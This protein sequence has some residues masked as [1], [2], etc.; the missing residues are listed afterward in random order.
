LLGVVALSVDVEALVSAELV[1]G[2][3]AFPLPLSPD[4]FFA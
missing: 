4:D 2:V 1:L 3:E